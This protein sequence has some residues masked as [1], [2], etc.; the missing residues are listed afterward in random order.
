MHL[1]GNT[2]HRRQLLDGRLI[3][4]NPNANWIYRMSNLTSKNIPSRRFTKTQ[5]L[6]LQRT[7]DGNPNPTAVSIKQ[8]AAKLRVRLKTIEVTWSSHY[9]LVVHHLDF[10]PLFRVFRSGSTVSSRRLEY[11]QTELNLLPVKRLS[12]AKSNVPKEWDLN[13]KAIIKVTISMVITWQQS[14][15]DV[16]NGW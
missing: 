1:E 13:W 12:P 14:K 8:L 7:F 10:Y 4:K 2:E 16:S 11:R 3:N 6:V 9:C 15:A 5:L